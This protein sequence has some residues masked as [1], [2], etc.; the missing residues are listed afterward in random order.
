MADDVVKK[1][2]DNYYP[3]LFCKKNFNKL[4]GKEKL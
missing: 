3:S 4:K 1:K 2:K